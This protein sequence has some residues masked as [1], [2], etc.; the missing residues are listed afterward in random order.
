MAAIVLVLYWFSTSFYLVDSARILAPLP[1]GSKSH[2]AFMDPILMKLV[3]LGHHV[4]VYTPFPK[5]STAP[6]YEQHDISVCPV[7]H[8]SVVPSINNWASMSSSKWNFAFSFPHLAE[9]T[10]GNILE[11]EPLYK[12]L[13]TTEKK[14]DLLIVESFNSDVMLLFANKFRIP[15]VAY[16]PNVLTPWLAERLQNPLNPSF[17]PNLWTG[18]LPKMTFLQRVDNTLYYLTLSFMYN[19]HILQKSQEVNEQLLGPSSTSLYNT[20]KNISI[21]F[22]ASHHSFHSAMPLV[23]GIVEIAGIHIKPAKSLPRVRAFL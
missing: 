8:I 9:V 20:V 4:T 11:C 19:N 22:V 3:D 2:Y 23:P 12:L 5:K 16:M 18:Y 1:F 17:V 13:N 21:L 7:S 6:N 14:Y 10:R 15:I